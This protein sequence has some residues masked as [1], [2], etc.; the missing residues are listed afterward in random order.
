[1]KTCK[2]FN[3]LLSGVIAVM[4]NFS[5][6]AQIV[7]SDKLI[8]K[9]ISDEGT[10]ILSI[11]NKPLNGEYKIYG[12][13]D[14]YELITINNG[15]RN[16]AMSIFSYEDALKAKGHYVNGLAD[17]EWLFYMETESER[18]SHSYTYK[19]GKLNGVSKFYEIRPNP[20]KEETYL[21]GIL[22]ESREYFF[23]G[24]LQSSSFYKD[25]LRT[26]RWEVYHNED[27]VLRSFTNYE[28]NVKEGEYK[29]YFNN[30]KVARSGVYKNNNPI[31]EWTIYHDNGNVDCRQVLNK[32][33]DKWDFQTFYEN[34][35]IKDKGVSLNFNL[36]QYD[37]K[38]VEYYD[39]GKTKK[40]EN[41]VN[42]ERNGKYSLFSEDGKI[43]E[44]GMYN[45]GDRTEYR[46]YDE[47]GKPL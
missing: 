34:G 40:E 23:N 15:V 24:S 10:E 13:N 30:G 21:D 46:R 17:G 7:V 43:I 37:G 45:M 33:G 8:E 29:V 44:D 3:G 6:E 39:N 20:V 19:N 25:G 4:L 11:G 42:G 28:L 35:K 9:K 14:D 12:Y 47:N 32:Q 16:G 18:L 26:G 36:T 1:M 27:K 2:I 31:G 41:Y 5:V 38:Y 22:T